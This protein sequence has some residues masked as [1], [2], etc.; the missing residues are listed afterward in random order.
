MG[1]SRLRLRFTQ[2]LSKLCRVCI[3]KALSGSTV[4]ISLMDLLFIPSLASAIATVYLRYPII[5][6]W[7]KHKVV[8]IATLAAALS[9]SEGLPSSIFANLQ[10]SLPNSF[11]WSCWRTNICDRSD[12]GQEM[13]GQEVVKKYFS[14]LEF[15]RKAEQLS[16]RF[17][18]G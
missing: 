9:F 2:P 6:I 16:C 18:I 15:H 17:S 3:G 10:R 5:L 14:V 11:R 13:G 7:L 8:T 4:V 1:L 12:L